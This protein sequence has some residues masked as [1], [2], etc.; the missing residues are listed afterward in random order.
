MILL[1]GGVI[2]YMYFI[3]DGYPGAQANMVRTLAVTF[4]AAGICIICL[5]SDWWMRH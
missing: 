5:T 1:I 3:Q 4:L 2:A